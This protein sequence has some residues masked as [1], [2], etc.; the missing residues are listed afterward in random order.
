MTVIGHTSISYRDLVLQATSYTPAAGA[1]NATAILSHG[2]GSNRIEYGLFPALGRRLAEKGVGSFAFDRAG[3]GESDGSF[4]TL[5][6]ENEIDQLT[7][8]IDQVAASAPSHGIHL[9]GMSM[10]AVVSSAAAARRSHRVSSLTLISPAAV[11][12]DEISSGSLQG[13][14]T[15]VSEAGY[16]DFMGTRLGP[17]FLD[18][19]KRFDPYREARGFTGPVRVLHGGKDPIVPAVYAQRYREVYGDQCRL[20]IRPD[21]DHGFAT[22]PD[23]EFLLDEVAAFII[24][25]DNVGAGE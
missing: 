1:S 25:N 16:F 8:V 17:T 2:F 19:A 12:S 9:V 10:G 5:S 13:K 18:E 6:T 14:P 3:Q 22:V 24:D 15:D 11:F 7:S 23:R 20:S 4:F 21:A